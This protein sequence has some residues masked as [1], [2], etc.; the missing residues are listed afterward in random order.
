MIQQLQDAR[1]RKAQKLA[2]QVALF[3]SLPSNARVALPL[4]CALLGRSRAS[5]YRDVRE[6][7]IP[8]PEK[9]GL[10]SIRWKA[11]DVRQYLAGVA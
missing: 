7:R 10:R 6:G 4:V 1:Q 3:D 8:A 2:E 5:I 9:A 11:G